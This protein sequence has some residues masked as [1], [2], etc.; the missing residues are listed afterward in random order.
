MNRAEAPTVAPLSAPKKAGSRITRACP[1]CGYTFRGR[2]WGGID[3]HW[4]AFHNNIMP[5]NDAWPIIKAG[6]KPS[7]KLAGQPSVHE[8]RDAL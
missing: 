5:Y 4:K 2:T 1:E 3:A 7:S 8:L 6:G